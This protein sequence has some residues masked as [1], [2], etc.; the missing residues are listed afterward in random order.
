MGTPNPATDQADERWGGHVPI[1]IRGLPFPQSGDLNVFFH[2]V[3]Q[4]LSR[5]FE[6]NEASLPNL[7][8]FGAILRDE[9]HQRFFYQ[10]GYMGYLPLSSQVVTYFSPGSLKSEI[11]AR[12]ERDFDLQATKKSVLGFTPPP[13]PLQKRFA[14]HRA[15]H[16]IGGPELEEAQRASKETRERRLAH[17]SAAVALERFTVLESLLRILPQGTKAL[18]SLV[19]DLRRFMAEASV[20]LD[21]RGDPPIIVPLE[22]PLLQSQVL[23]RLLPRLSSQYPE[24]AK[25]LIK[26]YHD[27]LQGDSLDS[28]FLEAFKTLEEIARSVTG[29]SQFM[30]DKQSLSRHFPKLH[31]SIHATMIRLSGHRGDVAGHGRKAPEPFEIRYLLFAVCNLALLLLDYEK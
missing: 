31:P 13:T 9:S 27:T 8:H 7:D 22:E 10:S 18:A 25:E 5:L 20:M 28:V 26:A 11:E 30:F 14:E 2:R 29:E 23:D 16:P 4:R 6:Y 19:K 24:R 12:L 17:H 15:G 21:I 1:F 3:A